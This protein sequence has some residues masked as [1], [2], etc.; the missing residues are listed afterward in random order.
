MRAVVDEVDAV[1][2]GL[3]SLLAKTVRDNLSEGL[4]LGRLGCLYT[5]VE[6][7]HVRAARIGTSP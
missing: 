2:V 3:A 1:A 7:P 6:R 5:A 4:L